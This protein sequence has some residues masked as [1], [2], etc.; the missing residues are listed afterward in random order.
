ML[1]RSIEDMWCKGSEVQVQHRRRIPAVR[2]V[3]IVLNVRVS[4]LLLKRQAHLKEVDKVG[5]DFPIKIRQRFARPA[6]HSRPAF[7]LT[8]AN[9]AA[10]AV[11]AM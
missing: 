10:R 4:N 3:G 1:Q 5:H 2:D 8:T 11:N 9:S 7:R 6:G